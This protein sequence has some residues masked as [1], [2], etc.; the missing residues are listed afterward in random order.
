MDWE[1]RLREQD[2]RGG[3]GRPRHRDER[4]LYRLLTAASR[5][6]GVDF[7]H[8]NHGRVLDV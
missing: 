2:P 1:D 8:T 4:P 7:N 3:G 5:L 6:T